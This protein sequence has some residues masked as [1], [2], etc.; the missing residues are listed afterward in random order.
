MIPEQNT[1]EW[2]AFRKGKI[3]ASKIPVIM[4]ESPYQTAYGLYLQEKDLAP[5]TE[6]TR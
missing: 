5:P 1:P 3:T 4:G 2:L 6:Q